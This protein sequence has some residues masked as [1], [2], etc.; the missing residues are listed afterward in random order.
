MSKDEFQQIMKSP[1]S[2]YKFIQEFVEK[3][4]PQTELSPERKRE[5]LERIRKLSVLMD[6]QFR[7]PGSKRTFGADAILQMI[8]FVGDAVSTMIMIYIFWLS[9][10]FHLPWYAVAG[11]VFNIVITA[12]VGTVPVVGSLFEISYKPNIRNLKIIERYLQQECDYLD[13][14]GDGSLPD[15]PAASDGDIGD[16]RGGRS[17]SENQPP[18]TFFSR[19]TS[20]AATATAASSSSSSPSQ[21]S[22][23]S[24]SSSSSGGAPASTLPPVFVAPETADKLKRLENY[25]FH[26][27]DIV[28]DDPKAGTTAVDKMTALLNMA[29]SEMKPP[30]LP[31]RSRGE[32]SL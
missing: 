5:H 21:P 3:N 17:T 29:L 30:Q 28:K 1:W 27:L 26:I 16:G 11:M 8:P 14:T 13:E 9:R 18:S 6:S 19:F 15:V 24:S 7:I 25:L 32:A 22:Q 10:Q 2:F 4:I 23:P 31:N 12:I 20:G